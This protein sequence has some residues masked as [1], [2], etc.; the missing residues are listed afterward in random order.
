LATGPPPTGAA[1]ALKMVFKIE[2]QRPF[3][4]LVKK[5]K[6]LKKKRNNF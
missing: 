6:N 2:G 3:V 4:E 1:G 5:K